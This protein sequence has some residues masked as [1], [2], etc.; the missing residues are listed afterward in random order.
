MDDPDGM[1][2][3]KVSITAWHPGYLDEYIFNEFPKNHFYTARFIDISTLWSPGLKEW[4][5]KK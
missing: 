2:N 1:K 3:H 5:K 4:I